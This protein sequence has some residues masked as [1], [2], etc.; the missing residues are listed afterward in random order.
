VQGY[1]DALRARMLAVSPPSSCPSQHHVHHA[2]RNPAAARRKAMLAQQP[3]RDSIQ[4]RPVSLR[5]GPDAFLDMPWM[6][7]FLIALFAFPPAHRVIATLGGISIV[8]MT[9]FTGARTKTAAQSA[10][11][12]MPAPGLADAVR[13]NAEVVARSE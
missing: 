12:S 6:P 2:A 11:E 9:V 8:S 1:F 4:L 5:H 3:M 10:A 7:L 13:Q